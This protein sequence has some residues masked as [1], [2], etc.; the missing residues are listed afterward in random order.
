MTN[1]KPAQT[2]APNARV[3]CAGRV[4][5]AQ[6]S[7]QTA[8]LK[9]I[10]KPPTSDGPVSFLALP[11]RSDRFPGAAIA[12][13]R[14]LSS[15]RGP[16]RIERRATNASRLPRQQKEKD[17][18]GNVES[19]A[20]LSQQQLSQ[21]QQFFLY[22]NHHTT[23]RCYPLNSR[24]HNVIDQT[25]LPRPE[26]TGGGW[27]TIPRACAPTPKVRRRQ[28][29][30][31]QG[32]PERPHLTQLNYEQSREQSNPTGLPL[33]TRTSFYRLVQPRRAA[34]GWPSRAWGGAARGGRGS[35]ASRRCGSARSAGA[36]RPPRSSTA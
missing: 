1:A 8:F 27:P 21:Q 4:K 13:T 36:P 17:E 15:E 16:P 3:P 14:Y 24:N 18:R 20:R 29:R 28:K 19:T 5:R 9:P 12:A 22:R 25:L 2:I 35:S 7:S 23:D 6:G 26:Q 11:N 31:R 10:P 34:I 32:G 30:G 33:P